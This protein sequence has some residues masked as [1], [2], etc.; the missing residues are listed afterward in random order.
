MTRVSIVGYGRFGKVLHRLLKDDFAITI[1]DK[2]QIKVEDGLSP[3]TAVAKDVQDVYKNNVI[4]Y[5]VPIESFEQIISEHKK[6]FEK[7]HLLIDTL[8]VKMHPASVLTNH[9]K[10]TDVQAILTH[11]MFGPDSAAS[12]FEGLPIIMNKFL[13][14][15]ASY[16]LWKTF[17][18]K[19]NLKVVELSPEEHD[20]M[21]ANSQGL[22][23]FLGRLLEM[24][25][26]QS[27]A[28]DTLG[29]KKLLEVKE[30]T[31]NDTWQLF[32]NLQHYNPY[33]KE[34][35]IRLGDAYDSLYNKLLP[36]Q[37][38][39]DYITYGIQGGIGSFNEEA[40]RHYLKDA[41]PNEYK[42]QYLYTTEN[43]MRALHAGEIDRGQFAIHNSLGGMV[44]ESIHAMAAYKF[45]ILEEFAIK[46]SH[47]LMIRKDAEFSQVDTIM[48]HPQV[49][50]QCK[51]HL[52][53]KYP[54]LK[55]V[56]GEGDLIDHA[57]VAKELAAGKLPR[58]TATMGSKTLAQIYDL[59][60]IENNL[61]DAKE[62]Y[63]SFLQVARIQKD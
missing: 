25:P 36:A 50:A 9:L 45:K 56:S 16:D 51:N 57:V 8:S 1:Y 62:N 42:I 21:A 40:I 37:V 41:K 48:A 22:T 14:D 23:H 32:S 39:P 52:K 55:L 27:S 7:Q 18:Q 5:A 47:A 2:N 46:I 26:L 33:T 60:I 29:T 44:G 63:T 43:V 30:L 13:A 34:M 49:F 15:D 6:Y 10:G 31:C 3:D 12:S 28:I 11:P 17:F 35:R 61:Q 59:K 54:G 24:Y 4:F 19:K 20:K 38:N 58:G 53:E